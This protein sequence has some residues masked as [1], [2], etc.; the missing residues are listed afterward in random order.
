MR[1]WLL[2]VLWVALLGVLMALAG[3]SEPESGED[4]RDGR[5][6]V[7][8]EQGPQGERG[9]QGP[10]GEPAPIPDA[11]E[12]A[13]IVLEDEGFRLAL[14]EALAQDPEFQ[15]AL[16]G[17]QGERGEQGPQGEAGA[18][19][20]RGE[21]GERGP[22]GEGGGRAWSKTTFA[23]GGE[24]YTNGQPA[25]SPSRA[26]IYQPTDPEGEIRLEYR[27]LVA[28]QC[29]VELLVNNELRESVLMFSQQTT[30]QTHVFYFGAAEN[31]V[32][33]LRITG[34]PFGGGTNCSIGGGNGNTDAYFVIE[35]I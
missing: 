9:E 28:G 25:L 11:Q 19:G 7:Q 31:M 4:G 21:R 23:R 6:G 13:R 17:P 16:R 1:A 18:Q 20:E 32:I 24:S 35:E 3:C 15:A 8:G 5:D 26:V 12:L 27:E 22:S 10:Q 29:Q 33:N 30:A 34:N 14:K 2:A